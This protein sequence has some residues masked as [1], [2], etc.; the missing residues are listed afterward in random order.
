MFTDKTIRKR[1]MD[2]IEA[3]LEQKIEVAASEVVKDIIGLIG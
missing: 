2:V 1:V 3:E